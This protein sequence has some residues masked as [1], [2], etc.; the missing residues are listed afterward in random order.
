MP[1]GMGEDAV[2]ETG[3]CGAGGYTHTEYGV[4]RF[5]RPRISNLQ[6]P[7]VRPTFMHAYAALRQSAA[8]PPSWRLKRPAGQASGALVACRSLLRLHAAGTPQRY[9]YCR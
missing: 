9:Q 4:K 2:T 6:Q 7:R 5:R 3:R 8:V 1:L